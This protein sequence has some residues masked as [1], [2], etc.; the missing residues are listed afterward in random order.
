MKNALGGLLNETWINRINNDA[1]EYESMGI[2]ENR[3]F[4]GRKNIKKIKKS[5]K[6]NNKKNKTKNVK[7]KQKTRKYKNKVKK[8]SKKYSK[9]IYTLEDLKW[10]KL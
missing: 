5:R 4:G 1:N 10:D 9:K 6:H 7:N 3:Q 8:Y 2:F